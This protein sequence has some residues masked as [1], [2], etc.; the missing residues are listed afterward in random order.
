MFHV[1]TLAAAP[2]ASAPASRRVRLA[3]LP[4]E[5]AAQDIQEL[6]GQYGAVGSV[7]PD[8]AGAFVA[9]F[10]SPETA[11]GA[12]SALA[13]LQLQTE[14]GTFSTLHCELLP[15]A[16][17]DTA[18][19]AADAE[20]EA[21]PTSLQEGL[22]APGALVSFHVD[23][24]Q[25][26]SGDPGPS[27]WEVF[28]R[29]AL[30]V[31][32]SSGTETIDKS[33]DDEEFARQQLA[34][35][36]NITEICLRAFGGGVLEWGFGPTSRS[37]VEDAGA[38]YALVWSVKGDKITP[39]EHYLT[40]ERRAYSKTLRGDDKNSGSESYGVELAK[41]KT[42]IGRVWAS[43]R[44][45]TIDKPGD[46]NQFARQ[47]LAKEFNITKIYLEARPGAVLEWGLGPTCQNVVEDEGASYALLWSVKGDKITPTEHYVT[48][49]R[50]VHLKTL[51][52]DYENFVRH[53]V[54]WHRTC[55]E[56]EC[57]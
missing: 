11:S 53:R 10:T 37:V 18:A 27:D 15:E 29:R 35:D 48:P 32:A 47:R 16:A 44:V 38:A 6:C 25:L 12:C 1:Q 3:E 5:W 52:G 55:Q 22:F 26:A 30:R 14:A 56:R 24:L 28:V 33:A 34:K 7:F 13:G 39:V 40:P 23:E 21:D 43:A 4:V 57:H 54:V 46:D 51:R 31:W 20:A 42:V 41:N 50:A 45:E 36:F 49:E 17:A 19:K 9:T 2:A 8:G